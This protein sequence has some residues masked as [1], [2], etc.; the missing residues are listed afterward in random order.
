MAK[1]HIEDAHA[2]AD[3]K[4]SRDRRDQLMLRRYANTRDPFLR[5]QLIE[6]FMPL[7]RSLAWRYSWTSEPIDDLI[8]VANEGL[9]KAVDRYDPARANAFSS[10][11]T[12]VIL[13]TLRHYFRDATQRVH[14]PRGLQEAMQ[15]VGAELEQDEAEAGHAARTRAIASRTGLGEAEV[16]EAL[17]A[18]ATRKPGSIDTSARPDAEE[19]SSPM[20]EML[21]GEEPGYDRVESTISASAVELEDREREAL[22]L[23]FGHSLNQREIGERIGTSQMQVS[24]LLRRSLNK[25]LVAVQ[26][27]PA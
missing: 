5:E 21:G 22:R 25:I 13:G 26:G 12:P 24:R 6:R 16:D 3:D 15:K 2:H 17:I 10:Y 14:V 19:P 27:E 7:A 4:R 18:L 23:R 8:Q 11:A 20:S 1:R 9:V